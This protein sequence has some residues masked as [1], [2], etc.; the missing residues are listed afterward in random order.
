MNQPKLVTIFGGSG[1]VGRYIVSAL[2]KRGYRIRVA[3]RRPDL[4]F[5]L[6]PLGD[7][8]QIQLVQANVR[9]RWS[10]D[11]AVEGAD[12]VINLVG[13]FD[14]GGRNNFDAVHVFGA[15][16]IAEAARASGAG[17]IHMS[18]IGADPE[19]GSGYGRSKGLGEQAAFETVKKAIVFRPS[20][21]F[22]QED[23]FFNRFAGMAR[24]SPFLPLIGGGHTKF[25]PVYVG[26]VA[27]A[28]ARAVDGEVAGGKV[29]E[30]GGPDVATFRECM[31]LMQ[32]IIHRRNAYLPVPFF[33]A[34]AIGKLTGWLPGAPI[35]SDQ[36]KMLR[37]D[38][39]VSED[40][41]SQ[42]RTLRGIGITPHTM[43]AILPTYLVRF[44]PHGQFERRGE[45]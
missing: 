31:D 21:I 22:G 9:V 29:Y 28:F 41:I 25:Q 15:R 3:T 7:V 19:S 11:R 20:V 39:V 4:A 36:V 45:V 37:N 13:T 2:A 26:D 5:D 17:L 8:G 42:G 6:R 16:A 1:F 40:A 33:L 18:A 23:E 44:R 32:D 14:A 27:E 38:N 43:E 24:I 34:G 10:V 35:T 30:L 12:A